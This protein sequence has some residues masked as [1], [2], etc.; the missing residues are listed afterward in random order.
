M[1]RFQVGN[2]G[3]LGRDGLAV[4]TTAVGTVVDA[5]VDVTDAA[6]QYLLQQ[7]H[8]PSISFK[9]PL[10]WGPFMTDRFLGVGTCQGSS[11]RGTS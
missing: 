1:A 6:I 10:F 8:M 7:M 4:L 3:R 9:L 5:T 11:T 2:I